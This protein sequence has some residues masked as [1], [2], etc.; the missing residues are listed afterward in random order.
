MREDRNKEK[1][2]KKFYPLNKRFIKQEAS[3]IIK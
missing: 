3:R 1:E 2:N